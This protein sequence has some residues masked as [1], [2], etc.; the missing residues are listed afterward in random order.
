MPTIKRLGVLCKYYAYLDILLLL[1]HL[2]KKM[3]SNSGKQN[4]IGIPWLHNIKS[5]INVHTLSGKCSKISNISTLKLYRIDIV[6]PTTI[7]CTRTSQ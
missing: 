2:S 5:N 1:L 3:V 7:K 6:Y 4:P